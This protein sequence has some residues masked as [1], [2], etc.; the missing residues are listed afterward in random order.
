MAVT[1]ARIGV[2]FGKMRTFGRPEPHRNRKVPLAKKSEQQTEAGLLLY[3]KNRVLCR[4]GDSE[5][6]DGLGRN[7]H[8]LFRLGI[9]ARACFPLLLHQLAKT[10]QDEFT[11]LLDL[12][13]C[14]RAERIEEYA[15]GFF[16]GLGRSRECDF[17][18]QSWSSNRGFMAAELHHFKRIAQGFIPCSQSSS[19][20]SAALISPWMLI[21]CFRHILV[22][23]RIQSAQ[24][25][26]CAFSC[27]SRRVSRSLPLLV[28]CCSSDTQKLLRDR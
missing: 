12:F 2:M 5:F 19:T 27:G 4:L 15:C 26:I 13:V 25:R 7:L 3:P 9:E 6:D 8:L 10:G 23:E 11:V 1:F 14:E 16:V 21:V 22:K 20:C 17:E 28:L 24:A 18:V